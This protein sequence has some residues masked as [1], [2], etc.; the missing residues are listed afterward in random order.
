MVTYRLKGREL[1]DAISNYILSRGGRIISPRGAM[2]FRFE[3]PA[4]KADYVTADLQLLGYAPQCL[5]HDLRLNSSEITKVSVYC[6]P[7]GK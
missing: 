3:L 5:S 2:E 4:E 6:L 7:L 1:Y